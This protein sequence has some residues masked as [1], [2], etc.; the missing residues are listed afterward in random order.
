[1]TRRQAVP[2]VLAGAS[3]P[4]LVAGESWISLFNGKS[5]DGWKAEGKADWSVRDGCL[6]GRQGPGGAAGDL[7]TSAQWANFELE[8]EWRMKFPGNSGV[9]FRV[10]GPRTGYQAD[11]LDQSS[12]PGVLSGS[13]YCMGKAF[14][15]ENRDATSVHKDGWNKLRIRAEGDHIVI[16]QNGKTVA[17]VHDNAFPGPGSAGVQVHAGKYFEGMEVWLRKIRIRPLS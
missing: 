2:L 14:I 5:L 15:A 12:H 16:V 6:V 10:S 9:W 11:F 13:L 8:C 1:V 3:L 7:F 17:D 4:R